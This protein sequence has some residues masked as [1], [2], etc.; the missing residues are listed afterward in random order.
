MDSTLP[1]GLSTPCPRLPT[2]PKRTVWHCPPSSPSPGQLRVHSASGRGLSQGARRRRTPRPPSAG[3]AQV[4]TSPRSSTHLSPSRAGQAG[5]TP[6]KAEP[7]CPGPATEG[8]SEGRMGRKKT[9]EDG[10]GSDMPT[11][12]PTPSA[13]TPLH[14]ALVP[15]G[16]AL[17]PPPGREATPSLPP[18]RAQARVGAPAPGR[19][20]PVSAAAGGAAG[21]RGRLTGRLLYRGRPARVA[22]PWPAR[23]PAAADSSA[24]AAR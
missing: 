1:R 7:R 13:S 20:I 17:S 15:G 2:V 14:P 12:P 6:F 23:S 21:R 19:R 16:A 4:P 9:R 24:R 5:R 8:H 22:Q 18:A 3:G 10:G 11:L